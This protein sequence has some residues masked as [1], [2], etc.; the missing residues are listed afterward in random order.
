MKETQKPPAQGSHG[1]AM[2]F[3]VIYLFP[4]T[5]LF[6]KIQGKAVEEGVLLR[7]SRSWVIFLCALKLKKKK[8]ASRN[9]IDTL[10]LAFSVVF[11]KVYTLKIVYASFPYTKNKW[12]G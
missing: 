6:S 11:D 3:N 10:K 2:L 9:L 8:S 5:K 12:I 7:Q 1:K 4:R